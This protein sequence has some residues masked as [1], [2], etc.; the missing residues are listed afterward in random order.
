MENEFIDIHSH[1]LFSVDDGAVD[2]AESVE[3]LKESYRQGVRKI[4]ATPHYHPT[5]F[6]YDSQKIRQHFQLL[7]REIHKILPDMSLYLGTEI[8]CSYNIENSLMERR[9]FTLHN[10]PYVL[11][12]FSENISYKDML[13]R[14]QLFATKSYIPIIAHIERYRYLSIKEIQHL[15]DAGYYLQI[16]A[17][18]VCRCGFS[19]QKFLQ[20]KRA[21]TYLKAGVIHFIASDVHHTYT[22]KCF[23]KKAHQQLSR[24]L[25]SDT[26][27]KLF[28]KHAENL[29]KNRPIEE[30]IADE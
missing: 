6:P 4:I 8:Y 11:V 24:F 5:L 2:I 18:S 7:Q 14:L 26:L 3:I 1:I 20:K 10:T 22:R 28:Y 29:L 13:K 25:D 30:E 12:E 19:W 17:E 16:N 21:I 23:M 15:Q 27:E 9:F